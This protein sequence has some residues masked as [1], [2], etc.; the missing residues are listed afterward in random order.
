MVGGGLLRLTEDRAEGGPS[1]PAMTRSW[2]ATVLAAAVLLAA[3][4]GGGEEHA[5]GHTDVDAD[6]EPAGT[7]LRISAAD[8]RFDTNCLA[9]PAGEAFTVTFENKEQMPHDFVILESKEGNEEIAGT[10]VFIGPRTETI[11]VEPMEAGT[12]AFH[13]S[14]HPQMV[15][16]FQVK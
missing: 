16:A 11:S 13:C 7:A 6:C 14:V 10:E 2:K 15:G 5:G 9:V 12:Y 1:I 3:C 8:L 4:G